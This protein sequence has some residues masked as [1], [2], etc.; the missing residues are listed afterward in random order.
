MAVLSDIEP[1]GYQRATAGRLDLRIIAHLRH[2]LKCEVAGALDGP[3]VI[4]FEQQ[5]A[6][7]TDDGFVVRKDADDLSASLDFA[8]ETLDWICRMQL[9]PVLFREGHVGEHILFSVV[10]DGGELWNFRSDLIGNAAPLSA[11]CLRGLLGK[12]RGDEGGDDPPAALAGVRQNVS[13]EVNPGAVEEV[14]C[15]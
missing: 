7:E 2:G 15:I 13:H 1:E 14:L 8:V 3:F 6:D 10:H 9:C 12:G 5:C 11:G 4:L